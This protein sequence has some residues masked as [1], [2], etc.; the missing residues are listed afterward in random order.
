MKLSDEPVHLDDL[1]DASEAYGWAGVRS[2]CSLRRSRSRYGPREA[3]TQAVLAKEDRKASPG[4]NKVGKV[5]MQL[6]CH[7]IRSASGN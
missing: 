7:A 2:W 6:Q 4:S 5:P 3:L 1:L